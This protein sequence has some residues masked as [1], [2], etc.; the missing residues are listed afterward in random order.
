MTAR[1][2]KRQAADDTANGTANI[3]LT[4]H[5]LCSSAVKLTHTKEHKMGSVQQRFEVEQPAASVYAALAE[6]R[7]VLEKLPGVVGAARLADDHYVVTLGTAQSPRQLDVRLAKHEELRR[8]EWHTADGTWTGAITVEPIGPARSAVGVHA[9]SANP[10]DHSVSASTVHDALQ[11]LKRAL[12]STPIRISR[13]ER[14]ARYD[15]PYG[16]T[17][18]RYASDWRDAA[19][20]AFTHPTEYPFALMRTLSRQVDRVWGEV[21][22]GTPIARLPHLVP[23]LP[24]NPDVEVCEHSDHVRVCIDVPGIEESQLQVEI[25]DGA[26]TVRGQRHD[27]R[28]S[29]PGQRRSELHYGSFTRRIPLPEGVDADNARAVLRNG[30]LEVRIPLHRREPRR[31]P[32]QHAS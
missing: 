28:L 26:L 2:C 16:S 31:V 13:A 23:G 15:E 8:V 21:W 1:L 4:W 32:V 25:D 27:D 29:E 20:H 22:R 30:V 6:P 3:G 10:D 14:A 5:G 12:Q 18:R 17:A 7:E 19:R 24:W 9:E 11:A